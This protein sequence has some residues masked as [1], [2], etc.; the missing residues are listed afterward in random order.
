MIAI[1]HD[2]DLI[3]NADYLIDFVPGGGTAGGR[4]V[5]AGTPAGVARNPD[6]VTGRYLRPLNTGNRLE[7]P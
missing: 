7:V 2:L 4:I 5:A 6:S 1:D 3:T